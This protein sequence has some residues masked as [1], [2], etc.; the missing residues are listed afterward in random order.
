M[1]HKEEIITGLELNSNINNTES[2]NIRK[3]IK[4]P[5]FYIGF[6]LCSFIVFFKQITFVFLLIFRKQEVCDAMV[7][8]LK[9]VELF[10]WK[11]ILPGDFSL[12]WVLTFY[13]Y[14]FV[15]QDL[16]LH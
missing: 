4:T 2:C 12:L 6:I 9:W 1:E 11:K 8:L 5:Q 14:L 13:G 16:G 15:Y 10:R 7:N 3:L